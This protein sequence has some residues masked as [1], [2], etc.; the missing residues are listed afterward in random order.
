M[1]FAD[2]FTTHPTRANR[3]VFGDPFRSADAAH[4]HDDRRVRQRAPSDQEQRAQRRAQRRADRVARANVAGDVAAWTLWTAA[5][6]VPWIVA[7]AVWAW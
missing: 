1:P 4:R 2:P 7:G 3:V 6:T 5:Y